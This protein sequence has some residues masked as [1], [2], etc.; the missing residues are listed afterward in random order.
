MAAGVGAT[1][2]PQILISIR[3][4]HAANIV[5]RTKTV[6]FRRR[7]PSEDRVRG[8]SLW[9][10][11][12]KPVRQVVG[13]ATVIS[14]TKMSLPDLWSVFGSEG[15]IDRDAFDAYFAGATEGNAIRLGP[16]Q[17][18][19]A[20]VVAAELK[21]LGFATPQSYRFVTEPVLEMLNDRVEIP[22]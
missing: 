18:L 9:I 12:T 4:R 13:V 5:K 7:F 22:E 2:P 14:V 6:E 20:P 10:Y 11:A 8:T 19:V 17:R 21:A 15:A 16:V 3:P 1:V